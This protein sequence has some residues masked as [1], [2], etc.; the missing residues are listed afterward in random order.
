MLDVLDYDPS[1]SSLFI[2]KIKNSGGIWA[3]TFPVLGVK[4]PMP[5]VHAKQGMLIS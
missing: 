1:G 2:S 3:A 5:A 4:M